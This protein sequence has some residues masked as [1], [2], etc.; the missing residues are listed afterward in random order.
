MYLGQM[1]SVLYYNG[2]VPSWV[3][4]DRKDAKSV[5]VSISPEASLFLGLS[6]LYDCQHVEGVHNVDFSG[7]QDDKCQSGVGE[8]RVKQINHMYIC[9]V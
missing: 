2:S 1:T 8:S 4:Y 6:T 3:W 7:V 5:A 9:M